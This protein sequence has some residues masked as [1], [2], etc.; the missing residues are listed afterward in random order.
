M[1]DLISFLGA[2][3]DDEE[4]KKKKKKKPV[5]DPLDPNE[6]ADQ[7]ADVNTVY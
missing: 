5:K 4:T 7:P 6:P 1:D 2:A 3:K